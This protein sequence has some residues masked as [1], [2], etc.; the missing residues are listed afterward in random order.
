MPHRPQGF[1]SIG[2]IARKETTLFFASP[3]AYLFL[4]SFAAVSLFVFFWVESFFARN[5][6]DVRPLFEWMPLL[7]IF[8]SSALTMR[9]WSEERRTGT[10][11]HSLTQPVPVWHFVLGKFLGCLI[12]LAVAL[13]TTLPLPVTV[14]WIGDLDWGPVLAGYLAAFLLG[15]AYLSIGLFVSS[16]S[17]N[18]I[19]SLISATVLC[20]VFYL[21]GT[22]FLTGFFGTELA[23]WL[24]LLGSGS[25]FDSITR[26]VLDLGDLYYYL[27]LMGVFL[28]LN[29]YSLERERWAQGQRA[30]HRQWRLATGLV[31][32]NLLLANTWVSQLDSLRVDMTRGN[33]YSLSQATH[34]YLDRL[35]EPLTLHGYFSHKTHPLLAPLVPQLKD[36]MREYGVAGEGSVKVNILDPTQ[37]PDA[38]ERA[39]RE[40]GI[41]PVPFQ[42]ADRYQSSLV[43]SYFHVVVEYGDQHETLSFQDLIEVK[44]GN[45]R[46]LDVRLRNPEYDLTRAIRNVAQTYQAGGDLFSNLD[47]QLQF[48]GYI[49]PDAKLP[50]QLVS[51]K[52][53]VQK[54]LENYQQESEGKLQVSFQDPEAGQGQL[55]QTLA[56][57]YGL[58]PM[59]ASLFDQGRFYFYLTLSRANQ[60]LTIPLEELTRESFE[61]NFEATLKRFTDNTTKTLALVTPQPNRSPA[62]MPGMSMGPRF[63]RLRDYLGV[64]YNLI[65]EDLSG[66][67]V[68]PRA[69]ILLLAAPGELDEKQLFAVDQFLM[70][71]GTVIAASSP[72]QAQVSRSGL[73][74][75]R[76]SSRF[77][78]WLDHQGL[79]L[80]DSLVLDPQSGAFPIPVTRHVG[81]LPIQEL[82]MVDYPY[83]ID[84]RDERLNRAHLITRSLPQLTIPWASPIEP[85]E[86]ISKRLT[87]LLESSEG[88]WLSQNTAVM[89]KFQ[90]GRLAGFQPQGE[91]GQHLLGALVQG[92]FTSYFKGEESPL[93]EEPTGDDSSASSES[94][95][96]G[97]ETEK[98][99]T[100]DTES[101]PAELTPTSV[102]EQSPESARLILFASNDLWRDQ[103]LDMTQAADTSGQ[104]QAMQLL[105]N[106]LDWSL[107]DRALMSIRARGHFNR[108]LPPMEAGQQAFWEY[109]NYALAVLIL[110]LVALAQRQRRKARDTYYR[111]SLAL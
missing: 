29:V 3:V 105:S 2:R 37:N 4:A 87:R 84:L 19:V 83:F 34:N 90:N 48:T 22:P 23:E 67:Q 104:P 33:Q 69:D 46:D 18:Q 108:T 85:D 86:A 107:E 66:G 40:F 102:I 89:P 13:L 77:H 11:E 44:A 49:S 64:D 88:A 53:Q 32:A 106:V 8:L 72:F 60:L 103:A 15:A 26:G 27:S 52:E 62:G 17:D 57:D 38:E 42:V 98:G 54:S 50:E 35:Q 7:L 51:F 73:N 16:R 68:S 63:S 75:Q 9:L 5:I 70:R 101:E 47:G 6:S 30:H 56:E 109:L 71:G 94:G 78:D 20:G 92:R 110:A 10:L 111:K 12:L 1:A 31:L 93:L 80:K 59:A 82:R 58:Q 74:M 96:S 79:S 91:R 14:A 76:H 39:N 45:N 100:A 28:A 41:E 43:S 95:N 36:L 61:E 21:L 55:A 24:R 97:G 81:G 25:R 99:D 65:R